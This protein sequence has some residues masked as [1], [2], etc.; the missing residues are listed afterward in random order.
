MEYV[1]KISLSEFRGVKQFRRP[2]R[3]KKF[4]IL[5]GRNNS[6]KSAILQSLSL[7]PSPMLSQPLSLQIG[8]GGKIHL[9]EAFSSGLKSLVYKYAG[10]AHLDFHLG[11][12]KYSLT[13][14]EQGSI[15]HYSTEGE[16]QLS[17]ALEYLGIPQEECFNWSV[18]VPNNTIF[19]DAV[20]NQILSRWDLAVKNKVHTQMVQEVINPAID[21]VFTE[22]IREDSSLKVRKEFKGEPYYIDIR[23][24]GDGVEKSLCIALFLQICNPKLVLWDDFEASDHPSLIRSLLN[25]LM[26]KDWQVVI[27]THSVDTLRELADLEPQNAQVVQ[28]KKT[29]DDTLIYNTLTMDRLSEMLDTGIDPRLLI[30]MK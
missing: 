22:L 16:L 13:L 15:H 18:Y 19:L 2:L 25:W 6:G 9:L 4:N 24:L 23:D 5:I 28:V 27:A 20:R 11:Q 8:P 1:T 7:L 17:Q 14:N 30:D 10:L 29:P 3:L 26:Q 12:I 21:E